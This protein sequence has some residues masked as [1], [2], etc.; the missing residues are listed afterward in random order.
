MDGDRAHEAM[1]ND[2]EA[3]SW[4]VSF[5]NSSNKSQVRDNAMKPAHASFHLET[6]LKKAICT[7]AELMLIMLMNNTM[8]QI[9]DWLW[10]HIR[11]MCTAREL[12]LI[13]TL[14]HDDEARELL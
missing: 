9:L 2:D 13:Q 14:V 4:F 5:R 3:S 10:T 6:L 1:N 11:A 8:K 12:M 7:A